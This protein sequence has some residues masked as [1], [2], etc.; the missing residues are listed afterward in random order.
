VVPEAPAL[1]TI[2]GSFLTD[3]RNA[4]RVTAD[5]L[6]AVSRSLDPFGVR[7]LRLVPQ[8][9]RGSRGTE[10]GS[11]AL[12]VAFTGEQLVSVCGSMGVGCLRSGRWGGGGIS[13]SAVD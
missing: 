11:R 9:G 7:G 6:V 4:A 3:V 5:L 13:A 10:A 12:D 1:H 8:P 2:M